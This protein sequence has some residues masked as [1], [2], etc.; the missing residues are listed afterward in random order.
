MANG[1][2]VCELPQD[3]IGDQ[4]LPLRVVLDKRLDMSLQE[5]GCD[6]H[7][8]LLVHFSGSGQIDLKTGLAERPR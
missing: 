8:S 4:R 3:I 7:L 2:R 6:R 1:G 5:I